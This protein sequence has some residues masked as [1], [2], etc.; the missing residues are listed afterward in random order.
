[1]DVLE[2]RGGSRKK[3]QGHGCAVP[4]IRTL[5]AEAILGLDTGL[6]ISFLCGQN[7]SERVSDVQEDA[8]RITTWSRLRRWKEK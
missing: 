2:L 4:A 1:M 8:G 3:R 6:F 7:Q 5:V